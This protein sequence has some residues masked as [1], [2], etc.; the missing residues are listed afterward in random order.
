MIDYRQKLFPG[1]CYHVYNHAVGQDA[2][3]RVDENYRFFLKKY[4]MYISPIADTFAYC[5]LP[6]HFHFLIRIHDPETLRALP[7]FHKK[8]FEKLSDSEQQLSD[9]KGQLSDSYAQYI[10]SCFRRYF[11]SYSQAYNIYFKRRGSVFESRMKRKLIESQEYF[12]NALNYIHLNPVSHSFVQHP[13]E[14]PY[15]SYS[16]FFAS[17]PSKVNT[18]YVLALFG[19]IENFR[20]AHDLRKASRYGVEMALGY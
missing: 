9:S 18:G 10:S 11:S 14:W 1:Q 15:S 16:A 8:L 19:N 5:L 3:F 12:F 7:E 6:N 4:A 17:T 2:L 20:N 13:E